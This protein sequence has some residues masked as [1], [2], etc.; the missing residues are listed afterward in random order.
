VRKTLLAC[1]ALAPLVYIATDILAA[2]RYAGYS[3]SDQAVSELFAIGAP[4]SGLVVPLF[5]LSSALLLPFALGV[6]SS[7]G[8]NRAMRIMAWMIVGNALD[9]LLLWNFFP[10]H[11]RGVVPTFTDSMHAILAINPFVLLTIAFALAACR[12][13]F[14]LYSLATIVM[15]LAPATLAFFYVAA[16]AASQPTPG[17]GLA[18]RAG[19]YAHQLWQVVFALVLLSAGPAQTSART[20][21]HAR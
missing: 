9:A 11:M 3:F 18:E 14:R 8:G 10:M 16:L 1:G 4:T 20:A 17:L 7:A 19:Q 6:G 5:T 13:W 15:M 12:G 2:R 21:A